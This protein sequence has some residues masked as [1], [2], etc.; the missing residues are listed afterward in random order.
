MLE[1]SFLI[2]FFLIFERKRRAVVAGVAVVFTGRCS[3]LWSQ[4]CGTHKEGNEIIYYKEKF[5]KKDE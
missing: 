3:V 4:F 2:K 5:L 1:I